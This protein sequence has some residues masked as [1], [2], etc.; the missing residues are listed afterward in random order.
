[1]AGY[2]SCIERGDALPGIDCAMHD[3]GVNDAIVIESLKGLDQSQCNPLFKS[4]CTSELSISMIEL[5][6]RREI[7]QLFLENEPEIMSQFKLSC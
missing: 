3:L 4:A 2:W 6:L 1:M 5:F 7:T